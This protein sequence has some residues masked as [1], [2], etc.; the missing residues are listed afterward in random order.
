MI[1]KTFKRYENKYQLDDTQLKHLLPILLTQM[2]PDDYTAK[3]D[4]YSIFNIYFDTEN[5][6]IIR[7]SLSKPYYKEKLRLRSYSIPT[8]QDDIVFLELKKK[9]GGIVSKRRAALTL[10]EAYCFI[11]KM[12]YPEETNAINHLVLEEI[13]FFLMN[14]IVE[15]KTY[16]GYERIAYVGKNEP[17]LR[18]TFDYNIKSRQ[19]SLLLEKGHF[20]NLLLPQNE[21]LMEIKIL[22]SI[23]L[24]LTHALS[25]LKIY[26]TSFSKYGKAYQD[27]RKQNMGKI[28]TLPV[29][30]SNEIS[31]CINN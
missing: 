24:W 26:S 14:H 6:D 5:Y 27:Y 4:G 3:H 9:I 17:E 25:E 20:G 19:N 12:E 29:Y 22:G 13:E 21:Y 31:Y 2:K 8:S 28:I 23:P 1:T 11:S 16:I 15:P 18:V 30:T 7:H 10:N